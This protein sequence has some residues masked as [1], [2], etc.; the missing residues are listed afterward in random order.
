LD[1][2]KKLLATFLVD[3]DFHLKKDFAI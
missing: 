2:N 1:N 3:L